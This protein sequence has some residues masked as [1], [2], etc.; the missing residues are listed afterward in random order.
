MKNLRF[1]LAGNKAS[2]IDQLCTDD[3]PIYSVVCK[4][5]MIGV[6]SCAPMLE[7]Y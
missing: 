5:C 7:N 3:I 4:N 2:V 1:S 6:S